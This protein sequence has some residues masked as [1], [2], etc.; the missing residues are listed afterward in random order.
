MSGPIQQAKEAFG[1]RLR[2]I[3]KDAGLT[4][5]AL[6]QRTGWH[7]TK[8]SRVE[9]GGQGL[10]DNEI[11]AW[12][13]I[14]GAEDQIPDLIAQARAVKS[15]Y[16]EWKRE[17]RAGLRRLQVV[18][19]PLYEQT[20]LFRVYE[21]NV[22]PGLLHTSAY[23]KETMGYWVRLLDLPDDTAAATEARLQRQ[24][25]LH[26]GD[27]RFVF[28]LAE[29]TLRTRV[30]SLETMVEQLD[31]LMAVMTLPRVSVGIL[32]TVSSFEVR[33]QTAFWIF[34]ASLVRVE[35]LT[36][37]VEVTRP[38]EIGLYITVFNEMREAAVF[39]DAARA[40]ILKA[41]DELLQPPAMSSPQ[42]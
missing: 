12:C 17:A 36:A 42:P 28:L 33:T 21:H 10:S 41:R 9:H 18:S 5:R 6:A 11:R 22:L 32:P 16:R 23:A 4:G 19:I 24:R 13:S 8:V 20:K 25:V 1:A 35:T 37:S 7:F 14:C 15:A 40:L 31:H 39:G 26:A 2:D 27:H 3:R 30:G 34:D 38:S 29:Q